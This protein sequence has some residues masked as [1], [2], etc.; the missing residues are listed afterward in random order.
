MATV[1]APASRR[2]NLAHWW[3]LRSPEERRGLAVLGG[4]VALGVLWLAVWQPVVRD[5]D[6]LR[7]RI[8]GDRAELAE[9]RRDSDAIA[10]L[11][12]VAPVAPAAD[13]RTALDAVL[14][15]RGLASAATQIE[16]VDND[17]LRVTFDAIDFDALAAALDGLQREAHL[18]AIEVVATARA[19]AGRVR[20]DVTLGR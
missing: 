4:I 16:R 5:V 11:A 20:A 18:R 12:R 6:R 2:E 7:Q 3:Q 15:A 14:S 13:P 8:A 9:A 1:H 19:D 10:A 17:R